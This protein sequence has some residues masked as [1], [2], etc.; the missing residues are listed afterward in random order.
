M[1]LNQWIVYDRFTGV[2]TWIKDYPLWLVKAGDEFTDKDYITVQRMVNLVT[3]QFQAKISLTV[4]RNTLKSFCREFYYDSPQDWLNS[5]PSWDGKKRIQSLLSAMNT[6]TDQLHQ[7]MFFW[8]ACQFVN[9]ITTP[10]CQA[11]YMLLLI[12][13]Q[14]ARKTSILDRF[15]MMKW[16]G[17]IKLAELIRGNTNTVSRKLQG[18]VIVNIDEWGGIKRQD[19]EAVKTFISDTFDEYD[20]KWQEKT[21]KGLRRFALSGTT[22]IEEAFSD[23]TGARRYFP[24]TVGGYITDEQ[25]KLI[26]HLW[27]LI[28][29]EVR[30]R[31][32]AG[33][34]CYPNPEQRKEI[35]ILQEGEYTEQ[36][37]ATNHIHVNLDELLINRKVT[38]FTLWEVYSL[39]CKGTALNDRYESFLKDKALEHS[40]REAI[41]TWRNDQG[42]VIDNHT[43]PLNRVDGKYR[44]YVLVG[45]TNHTKL[46][47]TQEYRERV[48]NVRQWQDNVENYP[49]TRVQGELL[50]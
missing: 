22:N 13:E 19:R 27:P 23:P 45:V 50:S 20:V 37:E 33:E 11:D 49:E 38:A 3:G 40:I 6:R 8:W 12:G 16:T 15:G 48:A 31:M 39:K 46:E 30:A 35:Q 28:V 10:G 2:L 32:A 25:L 47:D 44:H 36:S 14:G 21:E 41:K 4:I 29:S 9:R 5:L 1:L 26:D 34:Q 7:N 43:K 17:K 24:F 18:K 42:I